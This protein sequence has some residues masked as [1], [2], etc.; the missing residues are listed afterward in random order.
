MED[1]WVHIP[2]PPSTTP[3]LRR[4][5]VRS[6]ETQR[7][8]CPDGQHRYVPQLVGIF[9][10]DIPDQHVSDLTMADI[11]QHISHLIAGDPRLRASAPSLPASAPRPNRRPGSVNLR[12]QYTDLPE[13]QGVE[14]PRLSRMPPNETSL[15]GGSAGTVE[16]IMVVRFI[17]ST[18]DQ[19]V[20][21]SK[22]IQ[23]LDHISVQCLL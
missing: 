13:G 6:S 7:T 2:T 17:L 5:D 16:R 12:I 21:A 8:P 9:D 20:I 3:R 14:I 4:R 22:Y 1:N 11:Q 18:N 15:R 19:I 10:I 23:A